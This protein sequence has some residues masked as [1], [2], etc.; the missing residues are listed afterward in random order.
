MPTVEE[1]VSSCEQSI[2]RLASN[3]LDITDLAATLTALNTSITNLNTAVNSLLMR[4]SA[5]EQYNINQIS[6]S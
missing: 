2:I 5:L 1:R 6:A 3:K 4:I